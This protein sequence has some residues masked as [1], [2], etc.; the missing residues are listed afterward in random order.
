MQ[1]GGAVTDSAAYGTT[2]GSRRSNSP[3]LWISF[4]TPRSGSDDF[5]AGYNSVAG[6]GRGRGAKSNV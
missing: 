2:R 5:S 4:R 3:L 6:F 1:D